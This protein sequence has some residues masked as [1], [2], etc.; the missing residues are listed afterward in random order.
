MVFTEQLA[1]L[2]PPPE[3]REMWS[4]RMRL[5][6]KGNRRQCGVAGFLLPLALAQE[7][8]LLVTVLMQCP[9][10]LIWLYLGSAGLMQM[11]KCLVCKL[12]K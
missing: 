5:H 11:V 3:V 2:S 10:W 7:C 6:G 8:G 1:W 9:W 4:A 12:A